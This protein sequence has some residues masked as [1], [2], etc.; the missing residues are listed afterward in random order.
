MGD[1]SALAIDTDAGD[2]MP[3]PRKSSARP[4]SSNVS[5]VREWTAIALDSIAR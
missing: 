1:P 4:I 3:A 5:P 2:A